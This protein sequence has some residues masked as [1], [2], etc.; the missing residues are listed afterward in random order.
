MSS[1]H[2]ALILRVGEEPTLLFPHQQRVD[3]RQ[4]LERHAAACPHCVM[5]RRQIWSTDLQMSTFTP[6]RLCIGGRNLA[7]WIVE[8]PP[9][10]TQ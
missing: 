4:S 7:K 10:S 9:T 8:R 6:S 1:M 3:L 2:S 5:E